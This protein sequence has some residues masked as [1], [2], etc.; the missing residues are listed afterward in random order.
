MSLA[1]ESGLPDGHL[2]LTFCITFDM[3]LCRK[4][5]GEIPKDKNIGEEFH[6]RNIKLGFDMNMILTFSVSIKISSKD[7]SCVFQPCL[8]NDYS[9]MVCV[10][11]SVHPRAFCII[12]GD[13]VHLARL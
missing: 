11:I 1:G 8:L 4:L 3:E 2:N 9:L 5:L 10:G 12:C 6:S 13:L 7:E